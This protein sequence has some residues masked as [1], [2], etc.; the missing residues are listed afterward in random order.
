[1]KPDMTLDAVQMGTA[2]SCCPVCIVEPTPP[3]DQQ[4]SLQNSQLHLA[5]RSEGDSRANED[6]DKER[7]L[8]R[9]LEAH[10]DR[11]AENGDR[12]EGFQPEQAGR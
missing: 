2:I 3:A 11:H 8:R 5:V 10:E 7:S 12:S 4:S 9:R 6:D 1:M